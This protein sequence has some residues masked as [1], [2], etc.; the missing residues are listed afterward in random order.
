MAFKQ[1]S[2]ETVSDD[3]LGGLLGGDDDDLGVK[4]AKR[5]KKKKLHFIFCKLIECILEI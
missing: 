3:P 1:S 5:K 2:R 4:K